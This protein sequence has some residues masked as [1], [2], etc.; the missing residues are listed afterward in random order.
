VGVSVFVDH[1]V[2][3]LGLSRTAVSTAYLLGTLVGAVSMPVVGRQIDRRGV[4]VVGRAVAVA[5]AMVLVGMAG[6]T[7]LVPLVLGFAG[8][9]LLGQGSLSLVATTTV[10]VGFDER[11]GLA[12]GLLS[13]VGG[14]LM[15]LVP[16]AAAAVIPVIGW[17]ATWLVLAAL[18]ALVLLPVTHWGLVD[19]RRPVAAGTPVA[20]VAPSLT[21]GEAVRHPAFWGLAGAVGTTALIG[22]GLA[23]HQIAILG[24]RGLSPAAAAANFLPQTLAVAGAALAAGWLTDRLSA[25]LLV[26]ASMLLLI[27]AVLVLP[28]VSPGPTAVVYAG[29][30]GAAGGAARAQEAAYFPRWFGVAHIGAIRGVTLAIGVASSALGPVALAAGNEV[31]GGYQPTLMGLLVLPLAVCV[32]AAL[33]RPPE[34]GRSPLA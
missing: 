14:S 22:T 8:I 32:A 29:L 3:D 28:A 20:A 6:V 7:G 25:R 27:G 17:R 11:R 1:F 13:A 16:F 5:F 31:F 9:R 12:V 23:F 10:A 21:V 34:R 26:P 19:R 4:R 2:A 18:V 15:A 33:A 30:A 24:E